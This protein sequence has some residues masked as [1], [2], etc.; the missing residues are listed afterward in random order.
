M[1]T[2]AATR[3]SSAHE[4]GHRVAGDEAVL[5]HRALGTRFAMS[6]IRL[7]PLFVVLLVGQ[8]YLVKGIATTGMK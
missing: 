1:S 3:D 4:Q 6:V 5:G 7:I 2:T 8:R